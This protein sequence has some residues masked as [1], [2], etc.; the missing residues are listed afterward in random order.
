MHVAD[1]GASLSSEVAVRVVLLVL[2]VLCGYR[3]VKPGPSR[4]LPPLVPSSAFIP[5]VGSA[6]QLSRAP[7]VRTRVSRDLPDVR[8]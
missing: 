5:Y 2:L 6:V 8:R 4:R 7:L 1:H 3:Y